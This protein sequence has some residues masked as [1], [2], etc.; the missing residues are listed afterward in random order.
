MPL[1][2]SL[3]LHI[4]SVYVDLIAANE[5]TQTPVGLPQRPTLLN[6]NDC[7]SAPAAIKAG[8]WG[9]NDASCLSAATGN[10]NTQ[11][12]VSII[13]STDSTLLRVIWQHLFCI[14]MASHL[15]LK[16]VSNFTVIICRNLTAVNKQLAIISVVFDVSLL[17][18]LSLISR[19]VDPKISVI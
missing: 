16:M 19:R 5:L 10:R 4:T 14:I 11:L 18:I 3:H 15:L 17:G 12:H 9:E 2:A 1:C 7:P 13:T 8:R 6:T